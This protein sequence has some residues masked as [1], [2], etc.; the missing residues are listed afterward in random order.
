[1][2]E[3]KSDTG[4]RSLEIIL[5]IQALSNIFFKLYPNHQAEGNLLTMTLSVRYDKWGET[6][7]V[8]A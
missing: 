7:D 1:M 6:R 8:L 2:A 3:V 5:R 4:Q